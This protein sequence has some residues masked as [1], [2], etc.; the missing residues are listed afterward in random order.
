MEELLARSPLFATLLS[1]EGDELEHGVAD[2]EAWDVHEERDEDRPF[3]LVNERMVERVEAL[4]PATDFPDLGAVDRESG[5]HETFTLGHFLSPYRWPLIGAFAMVI[6]LSALTLAGPALVRYGVD[7]GV[8]DRQP[9]SLALASGLFALATLATYLIRR[10]VTVYTGRVGQDMLFGLRIRIFAQIQRLSM[11]YFER[12]MRGRIMTRMTSDIEVLQ[13]LFQNGLVQTVVSLVM[14]LGT[15]VVMFG[16]DT[17]LAEVSMLIVI[18]LAAATLWFRQAERPAW[19]KVRDRVADVNASLQE[20]ISGV[21]V[22]QASVRADTNRGQFVEKTKAYADARMVTV[23]YETLYFPFVEFL[24]LAAITIV[25]GAGAPRVQAGTLTTGELFAFV[26]YITVVF[27]PIQQLSNVFETFQRSSASV[28]KFRE[29]TETPV[30]VEEPANPVVPEHVSGHLE[31]RAVRFRYPLGSDD[32][33]SGVDLDIPAGQT[34]AVVGATGGGKSTIMKLLLRFYDPTEGDVL[35]DGIPFRDLDPTVFRGV[36]GYVPQEPFLVAGTVADNIAFADPSASEADIEAAA[37]A[38]GAHDL[39]A[40]FEHGYL[41]DIGERGSSLSS[42]ERQLI[43]LAR[44][45]LVDPTVLLL[46]E[47]TSNLDLASEALVTA[48]M[49]AVMRDRTTVLVAHRLQ[50][51]ATA[52][53]ILVI[54]AGRIVEDGS[55]DDLRASGGRFAT[56]WNTYI[57]G[58]GGDTVDELVAE[59]VL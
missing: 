26:L 47:P 38:V 13:T 40:R 15:S 52:D 55:P 4:P 42:G 10:A 45:Q 11:D 58:S 7:H 19:I 31:L 5:D 14:L 21:R 25:L 53:R 30:T 9:R 36:V 1:G 56:L 22:V 51:A 16:M 48:A 3:T 8:G 49:H 24:S 54:D 33:L 20:T 28:E 46:D 29:L 50:T 12:E 37:R 34:V 23:L 44:A 41:T 39:I 18:P 2:H 43:A 6:F 35:L 57:E 32:A 27:G 59:S 17:D